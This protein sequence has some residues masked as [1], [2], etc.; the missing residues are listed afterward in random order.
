MTDA[1]KGSKAMT[2]ASSSAIS[3]TIDSADTCQQ[4]KPQEYRELV[5]Q[6]LHLRL[7]QI[8][9][10][11]THKSIDQGKDIAQFI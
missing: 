6:I 11:S 10:S 3:G 9:S 4:T 7:Q 8:S 2:K 5:A 1:K